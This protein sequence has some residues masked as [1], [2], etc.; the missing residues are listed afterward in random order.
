MDQ[1]RCEPGRTICR[2]VS[3]RA[4]V[5]GAAAVGLTAHAQNVRPV[6]P[7]AVSEAVDPGFVEPLLDAIADASGLRWERASVPFN[8]L[9]LMVARGEA[10]GFGLGPH[11]ARNS[12]LLFS[13]P[14]FHS[15]V[16]AVSR[17][18]TQIGATHPSELR[19]LKVCMSKG[20]NYGPD[21]SDP[22]HIAFESL[23]VAGDL[24]QRLRVLDAGR[25]DVLLVTGRGLSSS[26]LQARVA[27][28]AAGDGLPKFV[29][30]QAPLVEQGVHFAVAK[31]SPLV[32]HMAR[33]NEGIHRRQELIRK[34]VDAGT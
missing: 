6:V 33:I 29:V 28:A 22:A 32:V 5:V 1:G 30:S 21:L 8:R 31:N 4:V 17:R 18:G 34:L 19:G 10:I 15:T 11:A 26:N 27:A 12:N 7:I 25:C 3:R 13:A 20:A 14:V 2:V 16:W 24:A 9:A 23:P